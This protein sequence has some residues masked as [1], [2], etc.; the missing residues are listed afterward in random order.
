VEDELW[1][2]ECLWLQRDM[3]VLL[4]GLLP[5]VESF[6]AVRQRARRLASRKMAMDAT[7]NMLLYIAE[8]TQLLS[9]H[10]RV[11]A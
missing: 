1:G 6:G 4:L 2:A 10:W 8:S 11:D 5:L 3:H 7:A 9:H